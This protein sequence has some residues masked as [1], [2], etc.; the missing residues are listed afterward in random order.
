MHLASTQLAFVLVSLFFLLLH[1]ADKTRA[2]Y[3]CIV[4]LRSRR[5]GEKEAEGRREE[6]NSIISQLNT[7]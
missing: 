4:S 5:E 2:V 3:G 6:R 7:V 1:R